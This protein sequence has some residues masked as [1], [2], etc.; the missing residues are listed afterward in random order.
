L[1]PTRSL[2]TFAFVLPLA[3]G[4]GTSDSAGNLPAP[5]NPPALEQ[6][7]NATY[8]GLEGVG[9]P[10]ALV[11]GRW[12]DEPNR[13]AVSLPRDFHVVGDLD[14]QAPDEAVVLLAVSTGGSGTFNYL[15]VVGD[16]NGQAVNIATAPIGDRVALRDLRIENR[17]I[18]ADVLQAGADDAMCCPGELATRRWSFDGATLAEAPLAGETS[19]LSLDA[20]GT[21][22]WVLT[23]WSFDESAPASP[24]VT[25]QLSEGRLVGSSGCNTYTTSATAGDMPGDLTIGPVAGTRMMCPDAEMDVEGRFL[26][27]LAGVTKYGFMLGQLALTYRADSSVDVM[28]FER[29]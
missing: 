9:H 13:L 21:G 26:T 24:E 16:R 20:L 7:R 18:V 5:G 11:D 3:V 29:R 22:T 14:G 1:R 19:R 4:C 12:E 25:L 27:Q 6:L 23:S 10:V 17:T 2:L 28:L 8:D 15:A